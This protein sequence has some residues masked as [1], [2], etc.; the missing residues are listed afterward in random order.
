[1]RW[2]GF[3][4]PNRSERHKGLGGPHPKAKILEGKVDTDLY[5]WE[6][7][8]PI[9]PFLLVVLA[10]FA[11]ATWNFLAKRAADSE[12]LIWFSSATEA[13]F[14]APVAV[15]VLIDAWSSLALKSALF[16]LATGLMHLVYTNSLLRGDRVG[17]F[18]VVYP[19]A[20]GSGPLL[21]FFG[22]ILLLHERA[23]ALAV[24]GA[25]VV[26]MGILLLSGGLAV[27]RYKAGHGGLFWGA[28]TGCTI[29]CYTLIDGYSV[30]TLLI[31]PFLVAYA[32]NL[33]RAMVLSSGA[34]R[35]RAS[36]STE[37]VKYWKE[38]CGIAFL[39]PVGYILVLFAMRRAPISHVAPVRE[40]SVMIG[41]FYGARFL[42]EGHIVR[43]IIG[44]AL[45]AGGVAA[46]A[47]A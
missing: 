10:A 31:S 13:L 36:L 41:V 43:R 5:L 32:G 46:L 37:Y 24:I 7:T 2:L 15:W 20:R 34:Y 40:M 1:M 23:S 8:L 9:T 3:R 25:L 19:L 14:F 29:A 4:S 42:R 6:L 35:Q 16:L 12:H 11:H 30:K 17:D 22:A 39:T 28:A 45:I 38:A 18:T 33:F 44:S 27:F 26:S 47:L 21:S